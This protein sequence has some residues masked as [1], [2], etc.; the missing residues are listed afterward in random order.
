MKLIAALSLAIALICPAFSQSAEQMMERAR[1]GATLQN[2]DLNGKISGPGGKTDVAL[3]LKGKNI[4]FQFLQNKQWVPF[5]LR[6]GDDQ[7][8]LFEFRN[9]KTLRFPSEKLMQPI[10]GSDI[11]YEDL[12]FRFL[13]WP[14]PKLEGSERVGP[15]DCWKIRVNNPGG[16]GAYALTYV[17]VHKEYG[18]FM[19]VE[20]F[21]RSGKRIKRFEV[22][23]VMKL[24]D[25]N[26]TLR[27]MQVSTMNGDRAASNS[28]LT[29]D[30][31]TGMR[32]S[33]PR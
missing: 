24:K 27:K 15:H 7:F 14:N 23:S 2:A 12:S 6:L 31:P 8:D 3:F 29:F 5:H 16:K 1:I 19:K 20:G 9:G 25:G 4:Q 22:E 26:Y 18:A 33:G 10:A 17:W 21:D 11:T 13:Y 32:P 30:K 28:Y